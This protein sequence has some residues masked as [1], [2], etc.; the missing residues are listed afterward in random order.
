MHEIGLERIGA[1]VL[2][3]SDYLVDGLQVRVGAE[4]A[5]QRGAARYLVGYR[6]VSY[7]RVSTPWSRGAR[8]TAAGVVT[9]YRSNGIRLSL[10]GYNDRGDAG[11]VD[12]LL[13]KLAQ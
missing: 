7:T 10:H 13:Q 11:H 8:C 9:T 5:S 12:A 1:H 4:I 6:H 2:A 3:L